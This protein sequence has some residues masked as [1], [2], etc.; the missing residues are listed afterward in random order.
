MNEKCVII[1]VV[2]RKEVRGYEKPGPTATDLEAD[3]D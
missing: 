2:V 3:R 1:L